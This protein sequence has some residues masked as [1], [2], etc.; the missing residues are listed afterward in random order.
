[1]F[2]SIDLLNNTDIKVV[3]R[4]GL[5]YFKAFVKRNE[6]SILINII[7]LIFLPKD[8]HLMHYTVLV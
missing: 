3:R 5:Y 8:M 1:M 4:L 2:K 6:I 7:I